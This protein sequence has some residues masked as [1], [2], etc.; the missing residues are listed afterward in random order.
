MTDHAD[1]APEF[2]PVPPAAPGMADKLAINRTGRLTPGQRRTAI[3]AGVGALAFL[4][5]LLA[6]LVQLGVVIA[7]GDAPVATLSGVFFTVLGL[8]FAVMFAG[9]I[10]TNAAHFLP[11][12]FGPDPV[13]Y[14]RG[15]LE[16]L[17]VEGHR[18]ELPFS[19]IVEDYSFAPYVAPQDVALQ[20][21]TPY[22]VYYSRRS[23]LLLSMA[24]LDA[25]D[26]DQWEPQFDNPPPYSWH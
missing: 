17:P 26:A 13:R 16:I 18:P 5:C 20:P 25:P 11:E 4:L 8:A 1:H 24:A 14:A 15:L 19:F 12:A 7:L 2:E 10:G 9:L 23:R 22:L 3:I 21:G 6:L